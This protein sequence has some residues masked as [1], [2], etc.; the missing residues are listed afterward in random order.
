[1][2]IHSSK[3]TRKNYRG[4]SFKNQDLTDA[5]FSF[6][7]IRGADFTGANLTNANFNYALAGLT[8][9]RIIII[10][11]V[12]G[13]LFLTAGIAAFVAMYV[14][15]HFFP[16]KSKEIN[17]L[18]AAILILRVFVN[19][20]LLVITIRQGIAETTKYLLYLFSGMI[21]TIPILGALATDEEKIDN[22]FGFLGISEAPNWAI[23]LF[24]KLRIFRSSKIIESVNYFLNGNEDANHIIDIIITLI[25]SIVAIF[26]LI[27]TLSLAVV[28]AEIIAEKWLAN[29]AVIGILLLMAG[30][31]I[32]SNSFRS[33]PYPLIFGVI[34]IG[35][36]CTLI[37]ITQHLA[38]KILAED[39]KNIFLL[40]LAIAI[41]TVGSTCFK[42]ANLTDAD[43]SHA[44]LKSTNF[45]FSNATRTFWRQTKYLKFARVENTIL[46]DI[47]IR[48][49]L[50]TGW[51]KDQEYIGANLRGANLAVADL[52]NANFRQA[53]LSESSLK[54]A[55]LN[56]ANLTEASAIGTNFSTAQMSGTCLEGWNI[57][58]TTILDNVESKYI[59]LL[60]KPLP[61][62]D[63]RE[64]RP[65]SGYFLPGDFTKLFTEVLNTVDL[66]FRNGVDA[67]AFMS[68]FQQV[69]DEN[70]DVPMTIRGMENKGDGVV[71]I[72]IDV[73]PE[74]EK[75]KIH[76]Q[77]L[78][79]Y[80][81]NLGVLEEKYQEELQEIKRQINQN[82]QE[83]ERKYHIELAKRE[84][85]DA[86]LEEQKNYMMSLF[87]QIFQKST[88]ANYLVII[89]F[90]GG[91]FETGFP[92]IRANIWSDNHPLPISFTG[93]LPAN[94]E[95]PQ[96]YQ[97]W[98]QK[99]EQLREY[100]QNSGFL[101]RI[102]MK[103]QQ[104]TNFSKKDIYQEIRELEKEWRSLLNNWLNEASFHKIEKALR[105]KFNPSDQVRLIIQ[106]EDI[107]MQ[108]IPWHLWNFFSDYLFAETA[109]GLPEANRVEK[110]D[111]AR[112]KIRILAIFGN[113][114]GINVEADKKYLSSLSSEAEVVDL[115]KPSRQE[116][117]EK[118]WDEKGWDIICFSGHSD[119]EADGSTGYFYLGNETKMTVEELENS[120]ARTIRKGLQLA[121]FNSCD[122]LG[123]ARQ[124]ARLHI[125]AIIVMREEVPD[126]VA[127]KFFKYFLESFAGGKSLYISVREAREKLQVL[128]DKFPGASWLPII[129]Q[130][131]AEI[132]PSF[133]LSV[134]SYQLSA[135]S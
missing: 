63:D 66:I 32:I 25:I 62:T 126:L 99:Y 1:M 20:G 91:N 123:L 130:N 51:G 75:E 10:S 114:K 106:S 107:L 37:L 79:F 96:L 92:V 6:A 8:K 55:Y 26:V 49:L 120:L 110:L 24:G 40:R 19:I 41:G 117:D 11:I 48:E 35:F 56:N 59:Y 90:E 88:S 132:P 45:R 108:R 7:D 77:F 84:K 87:N 69:K 102:K 128:E 72:T 104:T 28:L 101:P 103:K 60:E 15:T 9:F 76:R 57:D 98:S 94:S 86:R 13:I 42:N 27:L 124:F 119:S 64:R 70:Q 14:P 33:S 39:S 97:N 89:N 50:I 74:T 116:L 85:Q 61:E 113:D 18:I 12:V 81:Q 34:Y 133:Q 95:I 31:P 22:F 47:K 54:A 135:N 73:P 17:H 93:N 30:I 100:H 115:V 121:I 67:K 5:D 127:R 23:W 16:S 78:K 109:I 58:H 46:E 52:N 105:T 2:L 80:E 65:S 118:L 44:I 3:Q 129:C 38:K 36:P 4:R 53:N 21:L 122:G 83:S 112:E 68:S 43:F 82:L 71:V 134:N 125:P 29:R 131:S 111:I